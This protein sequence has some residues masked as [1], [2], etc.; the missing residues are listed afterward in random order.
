MRVRVVWW[1]PVAAVVLA[2][3]TGVL[4]NVGTAITGI[5]NA[6]TATIHLKSMFQKVVIAPI[7]PVVIPPTKKKVVQK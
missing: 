5:D 1:I 2:H 7:N 4:G 3:V 6:V